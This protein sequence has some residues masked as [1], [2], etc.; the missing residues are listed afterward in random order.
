MLEATGETTPFEDEVVDDAD[1]EF[2]ETQGTN[3]DVDNDITGV[4]PHEEDDVVEQGLEVGSDCGGDAIEQE[5]VVDTTSGTRP[6][7]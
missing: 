6:T 3:L 5:P 7:N 2:E 4:D 1:A